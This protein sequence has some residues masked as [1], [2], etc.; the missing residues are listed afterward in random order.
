MLRTF[1]RRS[2]R[3][4]TSLIPNA[5]V[6]LHDL[7]R[8]SAPAAGR[9][10]PADRAHRA[11][12]A[13]QA[14]GRVAAADVTSAIDV[15]PFSRSAMDGYAV[16]AADTA[17]RRAQTPVRAANR[18]SHLHRADADA[19]GHA[20][21]CAE[22]ATGA[23]LPDG[24]DAVVMVEETDA[25]RRRRIEM[26]RRPRPARTSA[27]AAP[28]SRPATAWCAAG[29]L[30]NPSRIGALAAVGSAEVE[31][32]ARPR[33]AILSTGNEVVEP[34]STLAPGQIY[35]VNRFTLSAVVAAHGGVAEP[36]APV[37]RHGR[38]ARTTRSTPAP[39]RT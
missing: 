8:R 3:T 28:T 36:H 10:C 13:R 21:T 7:A 24:A 31:V 18:R 14:A 39:A 27:D 5:S 29:E 26:S 11:G 23:P 30:L 4:C 20:G 1:A 25:R 33:V 19:D 37:A 2:Y 6:H 38:R 35:D 16:I 9:R 17:A 12:A 15:P 22:I 34:G 32:Y